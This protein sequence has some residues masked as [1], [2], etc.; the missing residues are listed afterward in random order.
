MGDHGGTSGGRHFLIQTWQ[1]RSVAERV[2]ELLG[3][4]Q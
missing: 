3:N 2:A 1:A 4:G